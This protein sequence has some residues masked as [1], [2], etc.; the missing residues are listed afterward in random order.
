MPRTKEASDELRR[1]TRQRIELGALSLFARKGLS[2]KVGEIA[3]AAGVSQGL[4]YSYYPSK[5]A[6]VI[7]LVRQAT[8][9]SSK[10]IS[11]ISEGD[12]PAAE[13]VKAISR[14]M[15]QMFTE[16]PMGIDYFMF[17]LQVGMSGLDVPQA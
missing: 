1:K 12:A 13:V 17:M 4:L 7:E 9:M 15:C 10:S 8:T 3:E 14:M 5:D 11:S 16:A 2:V 6:L